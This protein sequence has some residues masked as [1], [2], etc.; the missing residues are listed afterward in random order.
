MFPC[1][2]ELPAN[3]VIYSFLGTLFPCVVRVLNSH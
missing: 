1:F 2:P 3:R